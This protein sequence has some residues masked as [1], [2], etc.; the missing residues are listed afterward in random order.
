MRPWKASLRVVER[1][2]DSRVGGRLP[3]QSHH[4][5]C[6]RV[7]LTAEQHGMN[8]EAQPPALYGLGID[9]CD[10]VE[11]LLKRR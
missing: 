1:T 8:G 4:T 11:G 6:R 9:A 10:E 7:T 2:D 3:R 5:R